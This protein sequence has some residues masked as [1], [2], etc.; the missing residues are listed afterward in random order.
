[1]K[2]NKIL[3]V[4]ALALGLPSAVSSLMHNVE[5][6][7]ARAAEKIDTFTSSNFAATENTY[8]DF[9][10]VKLNKAV[11]A[12]NTAKSSAG[13]IQLRSSNSNSGIVSTTSGGKIKSVSI[14]VASGSKTLD[15]YAS[16]T[17][18]TSAS[19]L[20][21]TATQGTKVGSLSKTGSV[22]ITGD[23]TYV[24]VRS[25]S[26]AIY[27]KSISFTWDEVEETQYSVILDA[28]GGTFDDKT[29][30]KE[31]KTDLNN[32]TTINFSNYSLNAPYKY[33]KL[34]KWFDGTKEYATNAT[35]TVS[36]AT[37]FKAQWEAEKIL[38]VNEALE[39]ANDLKSSANEMTTIN[40]VIQG[41]IKEFDS[42]YPDTF[43]IVDSLNDKNELKIFNPST[44]VADSNAIVGDKVQ[45][46]GKIQNYSNTLEITDNPTYIVMPKSFDEEIKNVKPVSNLNFSYTKTSSN[47]QTI[48]K[49]VTISDVTKL[50][51][52]SDKTNLSECFATDDK[53]IKI[54]GTKG[55]NKTYSPRFW[56]SGS[57]LRIYE[58]NSVTISGVGD[59]EIKSIIYN[60]TD[61]LVKNN[62]NE[63][64]ITS[65]ETITS[66][67]I[68]YCTQNVSYSNFDNVQLQF[69]YTFDY[70]EV[71]NSEKIVESG[72][73]VTNDDTYDFVDTSIIST[74]KSSKV[75]KFINLS[76][77]N[78]IKTT[79]TLGIVI[80]NLTQAKASAKFY[81]KAYVFDGDNYYFTDN[82][83]VTSVVDEINYYKALDT[84]TNEAKSIINSFGE[85]VTN[86]D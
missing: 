1:M 23:Y 14:V 70:N 79:F 16:N 19:D 36:S 62:N 4:C 34:T 2:K 55:S 11:Y 52:I 51:D 81:V 73:V 85:Y 45:V 50:N 74:D 27:L 83:K 71:L 10:N 44:K 39:I 31:I 56:N 24:G 84:L 60:G 76:E 7:V 13:G 49:E 15:I 5:P 9:K 46:T 18:F 43:T 57:E 64:V 25:K 59:T 28:N 37:A 48:T 68:V 35:I 69:Q 65:K 21:K 77:D 75:R 54:S 78:Q 6:I 86:L 58:G 42:K 47:I 72:L 32:D 3:L 63:F 30:S 33:T 67:K 22:K 66:L 26:G 38:N 17:P 80:N 12:G 82:T 53:L 61:E 8:A 41:I 40:F 29:S 20:Y